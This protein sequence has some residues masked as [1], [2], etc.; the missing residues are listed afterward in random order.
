MPECPNG[1]RQHSKVLQIKHMRPAEKTRIDSL[2]S[3]AY[4]LR[5]DAQLFADDYSVSEVRQQQQQQQRMEEEQQEE[6]SGSDCADSEEDD[7]DGEDED[8]EDEE[9]E[10]DDDED[11]GVSATI[12]SS[13]GTVSSYQHVLSIAKLQL[14]QRSKHPR[15]PPKAAPKIAP[16]DALVP[17]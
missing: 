1:T 4:R 17:I 16:T 6:T 13:S 7:G 2:L 12:S 11:D 3:T 5:Y 15:K 9:D 8:D 10:E 14:Q